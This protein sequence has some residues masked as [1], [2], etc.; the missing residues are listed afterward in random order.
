M[1]HWIFGHSV[2]ERS[3]LSFGN[4]LHCQFDTA[5]LCHSTN[6]HALK[7]RRAVVRR[8]NLTAGLM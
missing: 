5:S 8:S 3:R 1:T 2:N 6:L 7:I 4:D